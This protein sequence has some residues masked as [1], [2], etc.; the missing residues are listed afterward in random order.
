MFIWLIQSGNGPWKLA[1]DRRFLWIRSMGW[2]CK[3][4]GLCLPHEG[5]SYGWTSSMSALQPRR[6]PRTFRDLSE[7]IWWSNDLNRLLELDQQHHSSRP[8][9]TSDGR[10][11]LRNP[12]TGTTEVG[13]QWSE[14]LERA[15]QY[16]SLRYDRIRA[17]EEY[18]KAVHEEIARIARQ[19]ATPPHLRNVTW[20]DLA[21]SGQCG[22]RRMVMSVGEGIRSCSP[23]FVFFPQQRKNSS[24]VHW[25]R[26]RVRFNEVLE[27]VPKVPEKVW[28][29]LVQSHSVSTGF[30]RRFRW[31]SGQSQ[32]RFNRVLEKVPV[33][34][35]DAL[36]QSQVRFNRV[37][38]KVPEKVPVKVWEALAQ[39][40][41]FNR[42]P[43]KVPEKVPGSLGA[44]PGQVQTGSGEGCGAGPGEG[45]GNLWC[46]PGQ[47][48]V[49]S[50]WLG[51]TLQ[52]DF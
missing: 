8:L 33:K 1:R 3:E 42:V 6:Y 36:V 44:K 52:K 32:V 16:F 5:V 30:R 39:P 17:R 20:H 15:P 11:R 35:W 49:S 9:L 50:A 31:R 19:L 46:R 18:G 7:V 4:C 22:I 45:F 12:S 29:A 13:I 10:I 2:G 24:G 51:S 14:L 41:R 26:R 34:V 21:R 43:E 23:R 27:K 28:E 38:E 37:P 48:R 47:D 25:C 40:V